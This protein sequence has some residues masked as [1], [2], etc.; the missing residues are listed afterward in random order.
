MV[1][2]AITVGEIETGEPVKSS[3]QT[4]IK[5]NFDNL[6]DR[7]TSLE[8]GSST[9]YS[10]ISLRV[11]GAY[12]ESG[13]L[14]IPYTGITKTTC[15]FNITITGVRI[16]V[17]QAGISGT[18]EIDLKYKRGSGSYTSIFSTKPS[19]GY[20]SGNDSISTNAVL[21]PSGWFRGWWHN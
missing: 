20:A 7:L 11:N 6:D 16:L 17:D 18:T 4:K 15:N 12:G 21:N 19:V 14:T 3:T 2:T 1:F 5:A 8:G 10:N 9:V 13:D